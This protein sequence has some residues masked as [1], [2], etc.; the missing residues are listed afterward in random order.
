VASPSVNHFP[1]G[2]FEDCRTIEEER[3]RE[4]KR[5]KR[6]VRGRGGGG[7]RVVPL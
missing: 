2:V 4:R 3:K 5:R 7:S 6:R 1:D